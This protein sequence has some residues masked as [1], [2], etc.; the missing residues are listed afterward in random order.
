MR[1]VKLK[2]RLTLCFFYFLIVAILCQKLPS[3]HSIQT[4]GSFFYYYY[5]SSLLVISCNKVSLP[6]VSVFFI[7]IISLHIMHCV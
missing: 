7:I 4:N 2:S 1:A 6:S 3:I 5:F